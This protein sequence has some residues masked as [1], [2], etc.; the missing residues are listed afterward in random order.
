MWSDRGPRN[1]SGVLPVNDDNFLGNRTN[2]IMDFSKTLK[3][4]RN[5]TEDEDVNVE[6]EISDGSDFQQRRRRLNKKARRAKAK[7]SS[8]KQTEKST[9]ETEKSQT[10]ETETANNKPNEK[11]K[12]A[13]AGQP[14]RQQGNQPP[15]PFLQHPARRPG[16][17]GC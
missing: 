11:P 9:K 8:R 10:G 16:N 3:R 1:V 17:R 13:P 2:T 4:I 12:P 14:F 7:L 6:S 5:S 15:P